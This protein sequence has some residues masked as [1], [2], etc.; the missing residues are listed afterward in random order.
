MSNYGSDENSQLMLLL[1]QL[2]SIREDGSG[3]AKSTDA[4]DQLSISEPSDVQ[5]EGA[6]ESQYTESFGMNEI[7]DEEQVNQQRQIE[8]SQTE[9]DIH[10]LIMSHQIPKQSATSDSKA[11]FSH[12]QIPQPSIVKG[13]KSISLVDPS[14]ITTYRG[15][16]K[17]IVLVLVRKNPQFVE[18]V[19]WLIEDQHRR[20][21]E[22]QN[23]LEKLIHRQKVRKSGRAELQS[24]FRILGTTTGRGESE[25]TD[26]NKEDEEDEKENEKE[27]NDY[28]SRIYKELTGL[29]NQIS[30]RLEELKVPLFCIEPGLLTEQV[31]EDRKKIVD[32]LQDLCENEEQDTPNSDKKKDNNL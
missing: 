4:S 7:E 30:R 32:F 14:T 2:A 1:N 16:I 19:R 13:D 8:K 11:G 29:F 5:I 24:M 12:L 25:K 9:Q 3:K 10:N 23:N 18:T 20:E 6:G 28:Y 27:L 15:A 26:P 22:W 17:Y 31:F 21:E